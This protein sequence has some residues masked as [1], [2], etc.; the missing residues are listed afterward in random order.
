MMLW[1][2]QSGQTHFYG[3]DET[4]LFSSQDPFNIFYITDA[5]YLRKNDKDSSTTSIVLKGID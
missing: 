5:G 2:P 4:I 1:N 3:R